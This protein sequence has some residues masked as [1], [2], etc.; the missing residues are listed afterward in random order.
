MIKY[1]LQLITGSVLIIIGLQIDNEHAPHFTAAGA[2][3][4]ISLLLIDGIYCAYKNWKDLYFAYQTKIKYRR[5]RIRLSISYLYRIKVEDHYLLVKNSKGNYF[6]PVGGVFKAL[7]SAQEVY[8]DLQVEPDGL[9]N[10][11]KGIAKGDLRV[12]VPSKN[13]IRFLRWYRSRRDR[14]TSPWREFQEEL[15]SADKANSEGTRVQAPVMPSALFPSI[16]YLYRAT[17]QTPIVKLR[18]P[19]DCVKYGIFVYE[20]YDLLP[21]DEQQKFLIEL[22]SKGN[23]D[24]IRWATA[25]LIRHLGFDEGQKKLIY[26]ISEHTKWAIDLR[27]Y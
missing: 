1:L 11:E 26:E 13:V 4:I 5:E 14:E 18:I 21:N 19:V 7:P 9:F 25:K 8:E 6:Q 2:I 23:T 3:M 27:W 24:Y 20:I 22:K 10:T 12:N 15:L 16:D 17:V